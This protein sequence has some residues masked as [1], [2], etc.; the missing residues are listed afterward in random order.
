[1]DSRHEILIKYAV[2]AIGATSPWIVFNLSLAAEFLR[3]VAGRITS[4]Q[5][6]I[7]QTSHEGTSA[8]VW[9]EP[10]GTILACAPWNA[11]YI[12]GIRAILYPLAAGNTVILK[13]PESSPMCSRAIVEILHE[14]GLPEGVLNL[15]AHAPED[16]PAVTKYLIKSPVIK[17][18]NFT[19]STMVGKII[20]EIAGRNLKPVLLE[21]GGK[22]SAI[23]CEDCDLELAA[24]E[25][26]MGAFLNSGQICMSTERVIVFEEVAEKFEDEFKKAA[27]AFGGPEMPILVNAAAVAKNQRLLKDAVS[28]G[29]E[30]FY[31]DEAGSEGTRMGNTAVKGVKKGMDLFHTESFGPTVSI[32]VVKGEEEAIELANDTEYGLSAAVFTRDLGRALRIAKEIESGAVHINGMTVHDVPELPHGGKFSCFYC[33]ESRVEIIWMYKDSDFDLGMKASGFGRFGSLEEWVRSKTV[34]FKDQTRGML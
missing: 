31:G 11:P 25:C 20:A 4:I 30:I 12:L 9:K 5:G 23:V 10:Y 21:L 18:I 24:K 27:K 29:A 1:M 15:I 16:A 26:V 33:C 28:K 8:M 6:S 3:D 7:P 32:C 17:K 19:G 14:A 2:E 13:C 22:A 34:T